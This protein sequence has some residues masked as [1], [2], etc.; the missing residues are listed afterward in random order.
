M[1]DPADVELAKRCLE[2]YYERCPQVL[3]GV[4]D[5]MKRGEWQKDD[6]VDWK[7]VPSR[8]TEADVIAMESELP[9][10]LPPMFRAFGASGQA[11]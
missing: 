2:A 11:C 5:E 4:P 3:P 6:W 9:F 1:I 7:L 8:L 10:H